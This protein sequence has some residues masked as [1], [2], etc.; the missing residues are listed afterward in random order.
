M[1]KNKFLNGTEL[2]SKREPATKSSTAPAGT[3]TGP[4]KLDRGALDTV[5]GGGILLVAGEAPHYGPVYE[6]ID[7]HDGRF[8][9][10]FGT[11]EEAEDWAR[12]RAQSTTNLTQREVDAL[13]DP[14]HHLYS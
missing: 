10:S 8:L 12:W 7:D 13:R 5:S 11:R 2:G 4:A 6:V 14:L 3:V 9:G 1:D